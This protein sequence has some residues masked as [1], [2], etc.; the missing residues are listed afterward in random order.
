MKREMVEEVPEPVGSPLSRS[1][2]QKHA[3][4]RRQRSWG[5]G[6][7][8]GCDPMPKASEFAELRVLLQ[9]YNM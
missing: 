1:L 4:A 7:G 2:P 5:Q 9:T 8:E 6:G 3:C